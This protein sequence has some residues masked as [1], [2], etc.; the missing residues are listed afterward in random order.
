M[1]GSKTNKHPNR[2]GNSKAQ[3]SG[4]PTDTAEKILYEPYKRR[5]K[6]IFHTTWELANREERIKLN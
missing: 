3:G 6:L 1:Q 2:G 4:P 5:V